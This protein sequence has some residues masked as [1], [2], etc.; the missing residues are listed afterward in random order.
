MLPV[1]SCSTMHPRLGR[2]R[3]LFFAT[4]VVLL[5]A[6]LWAQNPPASEDHSESV[7]QSPS[8]V[9][10][11]QAPSAGAQSPSAHIPIH[12][13]PYGPPAHMKRKAPTG[14]SSN[15]GQ[16][17]YW[18]GPVISQVQIVEVLWGSFVDVPSTTGLEQ[19]FTDVTQSNY[20]GM[21]AEYNTV[22]LTGLGG[23]PSSNQ[24]IG[25]GNFLNPRITITPSMCPG[26]AANTSCTITDAQIE[27]ELDNQLNAH[28]LPTPVQDPQG[29]F[30][31]IYMVYFPPGVTIILAPGVNSCQNFGF[32]AYH[33]SNALSLQPK[34]LYGVF[35]DFGPTS[36]C[37][38][39]LGGCG[40]GNS[41]QNLTSVSSHELGEA[42]T[43]A[44]V[45]NFN[46]NAPAPPLAWI[47][48]VSGEEIG[49]FC[50]QNQAQITVNS[51]T[52]T[53]QQ[54]WSNMQ[55]GCVSA[56]AH[57][58][59][60]PS[61]P[62]AVPGISFQ[63]TVSAE[64]SFNSIISNYSNTIHFTSSDGAAVLPADYTFVAGTDF[65]SHTFTVTLSTTGMQTIT[66]NDTAIT[67]MTGNGSVDIEHNPDMTVASAHSSFEQGQTGAT[68]TLTAT[69]V[70]DRPTT[71]QVTVSENA[72]NGGLL[73]LTAIAGTGW[74]CQPP[75]TASCTR[76]DPLAAGASYP[77]VILT[78]TVSPTAPPTLTTVAFVSGG[79]ELNTSNDQFSDVTP[80]TPMPDM[81]IQKSH[82]GSFAQGQQG[83]I[84]TIL[85]SNQGGAATSGLVTVTDTL[86]T[87]LTA[88]AI[89]GAGWTCSTPPTL[90]CTRTD[91]LGAHTSYPPI[92]LTVN[93]DPA[94]PMP[95][96]TNTANVSG[97]GEIFTADDSVT[98]VTQITVPAPDLT[99]V[100][101]HS[102]NFSQGQIGAVYTLTVSNIGPVATSG[103]VTV[104]DTLP[105]G[106]TA[107]GFAGSGWS[108]TL[109]N[110][111]CARSDSLA[112][113]SASYPPITL[114][115]NLSVTAPTPVVNNSFV[116]G[117]G[118]LD[119]GNDSSGDSTNV[120]QFAN[121]Q[122][123]KSHAL[124]F[125]QGQTGATYNLSVQNSLGAPTVGTVTVVDNLPAG[126]T[127][128][129]IAGTGWN[130]TLAN[131]TCTRN[132]VLAG[133]SLY[134]VIIVTVNV[135]ANAP[136]SVINTA[137]V[138]GGGEIITNDD[139][140]SDTTVI[141]PPIILPP[142]LG[143]LNVTAGGEAV[144]TIPITSSLAGTVNLTCSSGVPPGARCVFSPSSVGPGFTDVSLGVF[145]TGPTASTL[146]AKRDDTPPL[147]LFLFTAFG[148]AGIVMVRRNRRTGWLRHAFAC[149]AVLTTIFLVSC[150]NHGTPPPPPP[151]P[152][153]PG[154]YTITVT[155]TNATTTSATAT[156][157]LT[158]TVH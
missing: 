127:A 25:L 122:I 70:G 43:D 32:C 46:G 48:Q 158:L 106:F 148:L 123:T 96:V 156:A 98:D 89:S 119:T 115:V 39:A 40:N 114:T 107:T 152:T 133:F 64:S 153:P 1:T 151:V 155:A 112:A 56:P 147:G 85:A 7:S 118:E 146:A 142:T 59:V 71:G 42:V 65:G 108:C 150:G 35:P 36:G 23:A 3:A 125:V 41:H 72:F 80:V 55:G 45:G 99:I 44:Q 145:T 6:T 76:T 33:S 2:R 82:Q 105:P 9:E 67:V 116:S 66:V 11:P 91:V 22:G 26:N 38:A 63:I 154:T 103:T 77:P 149:G 47:D 69:N 20:L 139:T 138:S 95:S 83:A 68:Y 5:T 94:A 120:T 62:N 137:S 16:V 24:T 28:R 110:L 50:N 117:G 34:F 132:D 130:C 57:F 124:A 109:A 113:N 126:L 4:V 19:F 141:N 17:Q 8:A 157:T 92:A 134:P 100:G 121:L 111:T 93:V 90:S 129:N 78:V 27:T 81:V 53:I 131:L 88:A 49:D 31:T 13:V 12:I 79:G 51:N 87:G 60:Q 14:K 75:P 136:S 73:T 143:T 135:A 128:T 97:G 30:D 102:G 101:S 84:Y 52:Y 15:N 10:G 61:T 144:L 86:P 104:T 74:T 18:G 58:L 37:S 29:N 140:A 54:L 21:L